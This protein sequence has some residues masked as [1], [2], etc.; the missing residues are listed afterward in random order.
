MFG[1]QLREEERMDGKEERRW[2]GRKEERRGMGEE[3][4]G[5]G[6]EEEWG[7]RRAKLKRLGN[8]LVQEDY[9]TDVLGCSHM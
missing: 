6:R 1:Y 3:V 2:K 9:R 4:R 5:G 8:D 7:R